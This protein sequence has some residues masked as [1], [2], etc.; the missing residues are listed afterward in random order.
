MDYNT[1][2]EQKLNLIK[3]I[4][5][6]QEQNRNKIR[7]REEILY[8]DNPY[9]S[10]HETSE[11]KD[12]ET[13]EKQER[14]IPFAFRF[15]VCL[16]FFLLFFYMDVQ[17]KSFLKINSTM[18]LEEINRSGISFSSNTFDFIEQLPYTLKDK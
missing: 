10:F 2:I 1:T 5:S 13:I 12:F 18:I 14:N 3:L 16:L 11:T 4:R 9:K 8:P 17:N 6:E 15:I 7:L